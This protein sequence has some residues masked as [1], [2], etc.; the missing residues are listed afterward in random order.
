[1]SNMNPL[2]GHTSG[3]TQVKRP[4]LQPPKK[5]GVYLVNDDYTTMEFVVEILTAVF[6]LSHEKAVAVMLLVHHEGRGLCGVYTLFI[7]EI[8][9]QYLSVRAL[10]AD[11]PLL[12]TV[13]EM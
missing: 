5:Y 12:C 4:K 7:A 13:E 8:I 9:H 3:E 2:S 6:A 11:F 10:A 1:M